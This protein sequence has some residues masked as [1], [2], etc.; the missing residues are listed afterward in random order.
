MS[1][2]DAAHALRYAPHAMADDPSA[3]TSGVAALHEVPGTEPIDSGEEK[4][5]SEFTKVR[6]TLAVLD[7]GKSTEDCTPRSE[8]TRT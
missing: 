3:P 7:P 5:M 6:Y 1:T 2:A 4:S 8:G